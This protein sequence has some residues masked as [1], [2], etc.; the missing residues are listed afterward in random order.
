MTDQTPVATNEA[1]PAQA[2]VVAPP[3]APK[4]PIIASDEVLAIVPRDLE[5]AYRYAQMVFKSGTAPDSYD[6]D[7][8][9]III[10]ILASMELGVPPMT[11]L[12]N[13]AIINKRPA[14]WGD[15][16]IALC[17]AKGVIKSYECTF[18]GTEGEDDYQANVVIWRRG[19]DV[20]YEGHF[21]I[22][23][24]KRAGLWMNS[25]KDPWVKYPYRM[26]TNRARAFALRDGFADCLAGLAIAE[27]AQDL[28]A[29]PKIM[30]ADVL[31]DAPA[32]E[33]PKADTAA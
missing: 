31:A 9:K 25:R 12:R 26:L 1:S 22:K 2:V 13:I 28:P 33:A 27:E 23:D 7:P 6:N 24:A 4:P 30:D 10:G 32:L 14:I 29:E 20:P 15:L 19:Q 21:S 18:T 3:Q 5:E 16:A 11:G 8:Q 17:Q